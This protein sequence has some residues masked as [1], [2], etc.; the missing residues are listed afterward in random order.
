MEKYVALLRGINVGG[1][2]K[3]EMS[4]LKECFL[5]LGYKNVVT[6]INSGNVVFETR[7]TRTHTLAAAIESAIQDVFGFTVKVLV[8]DRA[9][10]EKICLIVPQAWVNDKDQR[11]DVLFLWDEFANQNSLNLI[12]T[13][14]KVDTLL[15]VEGAI[16]WQLDKRNY[17]AS[18]MRDLIGTKLYK[19]M[20]GRNI[21][22]VRKLAELLQQ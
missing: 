7:K 2:N 22:T 20:T 6:Y 18:K 19:S 17:S 9:V 16:V 8:R 11:C 15:Y 21:N 13:N 14:P 1:N 4:R 10:I 5:S 3:V 12:A